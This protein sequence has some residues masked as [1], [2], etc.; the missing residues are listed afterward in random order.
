MSVGESRLLDQFDRKMRFAA[1]RL[2]CSVN[3]S[4]AFYQKKL[5]QTTGKCGHWSA[6]CK[7]FL[8]KFSWFFKKY[9][10]GLMYMTGRCST[11]MV[12]S[13]AEVRKKGVRSYTTLQ[14]VGHQDRRLSCQ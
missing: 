3:D 10:K 8:Y 7:H 5:R 1:V 11:V 2:H 9:G 12:V 13:G 14:S 4:T 6:E